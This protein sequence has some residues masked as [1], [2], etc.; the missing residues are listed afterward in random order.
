MLSNLQ[1]KFT[2]GLWIGGL[3]NHESGPKWWYFTQPSDLLGP[4]GCP[5]LSYL[6]GVVPTGASAL[7]TASGPNNSHPTSRPRHGFL[8]KPYW[9]PTKKRLPKGSIFYMSIFLDCDSSSL[10]FCHFFSVKKNLKLK[11]HPSMNKNQ[12]LHHHLDIWKDI[13]QRLACLRLLRLP[14]SKHKVMPFRTSRG[15]SAYP[16]FTW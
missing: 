1:S 2:Q 8:T 11:N 4:K 5:F 6:F 10:Q 15:I 3:F 13:C 16:A 9:C 7:S 12:R 14:N